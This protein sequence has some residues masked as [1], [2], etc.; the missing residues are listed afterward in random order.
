MQVTRE[1]IVDLLPLYQ[2]GEASADS[3]A[4][5]EAFMRRD[6]SLARL[7]ADDTNAAP[8][9]ISPRASLER[10]AVSRTRAIIR[11]RS[12]VLAFAIF[13]T[14]LP[15]SFGFR[16]DEVTF[17]MLRDQPSSA[18]FWLGAAA[19]WVMHIRLTRSLGTAGL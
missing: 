19:L 13:F 16:G 18:L 11:R 4:A 10:Q 3:R 17:F 6:P 2:S 12:W 5:V 14:L 8:E 9:V 1:M 7:I 15:F